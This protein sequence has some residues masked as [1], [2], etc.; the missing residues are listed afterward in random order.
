MHTTYDLVWYA[1]ERTPH[2][3]AIVDDRTARKLTY[4]QLM[5]EIDKKMI[6]FCEL[7]WDDN[8]LLF[9]KNKSPIKTASAF[10]ARQPIYESSVEL[11]TD[12][13]KNIFFKQNFNDI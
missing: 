7:D 8:C 11:D 2:H 4:R 5:L 10:Q 6:N 12:L 9:Y 3:L 1:S 13:F